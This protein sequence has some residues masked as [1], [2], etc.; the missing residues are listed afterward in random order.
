[1]ISLG[2]RFATTGSALTERGRYPRILA[3]LSELRRS[4]AS[5][6]R[7]L[8]SLSVLFRSAEV[9]TCR[10]WSRPWARTG[11]TGGRAQPVASGFDDREHFDRTSKP[12]WNGSRLGENAACKSGSCCCGDG[13]GHPLEPLGT[14]EIGRGARRRSGP[15]DRR[16]ERR[17]FSPRLARPA[18]R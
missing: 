18:V 11:G 16:T 12:A 13:C 7:V 6:L 1:M 14:C 10:S 4:Y 3:L 15:A 8:S 5:P 2:R 9:T 17:T